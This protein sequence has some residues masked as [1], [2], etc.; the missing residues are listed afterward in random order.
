MAPYAL[1]AA[2]VL[3]Q[4]APQ[5]RLGVHAILEVDGVPFGALNRSAS[6]RGAM[7]AA[8]A[9][10]GLAVI[11]DMAHDFPVQGASG[12]LL[13]E[14]SHFSVHT[15]PEHGYAAVDLFTCGDVPSPPCEHAAADFLG[16]QGWR[17]L[18]D[19]LPAA[20]ERGLWATADS[21]VRALGAG[22]AKLIWL[23]R[24]SA[25]PPAKSAPA[26]PFKEEP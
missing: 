16:A 26:L 6:L 11:G 7:L 22:S 20:L 8:A 9:S 13:L 1:L 25:A 10:G 23:A 5:L 3:A 17:C 4:P 21:L 2:S 15:W 19:G 12:L 24:G 14:D 18:N